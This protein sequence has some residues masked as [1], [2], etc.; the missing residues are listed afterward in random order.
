MP[1]G[2]KDDVMSDENKEKEN[3]KKDTRKGSGMPVAVKAVVTNDMRRLLV[4]VLILLLLV[5]STPVVG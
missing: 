5:S 3:E 4:L 1:N 2:R